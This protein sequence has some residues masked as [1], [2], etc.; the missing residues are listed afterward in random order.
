MARNNKGTIFK[1]PWPTGFNLS[2]STGE[3][4]EELMGMPINVW[5]GVEE[6][7]EEE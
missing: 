7:E 5:A 2:M 4:F 1:G 6:E 3:V